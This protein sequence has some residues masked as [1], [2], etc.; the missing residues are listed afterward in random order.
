MQA[1]QKNDEIDQ[2][3]RQWRC[4]FH[5]HPETAYEEI[6]TADKIAG[7][8]TSWGI[9][10][11]RG[12]AKTGVVGTLKGNR[13]GNMIGLRADMDALDITE[14]NDFLY[15]SKNV[16]KMHACGHDGHMAML[17]GA[18]YYLSQ[19]RDFAGTVVFIFQPA[20]ENVAGGKLM[21]DEG[22]FELFPVKEVYGLHNWPDLEE[23]VIG[24]HDKEV[25]ASYDVFDIIIKGKG[26]HGAQPQKGIDPVLIA[27]HIVVALQSIV[28]RNIPPSE[29]AVL[30]VTKIHGGEMNNIIPNEVAIGGGCR[31]FSSEVRYLLK[32]NIC[33][34]ATDVANSFG[35]TV[36]IDYQLR[37]PPTVNH[38]AQAQKIAKVAEKLF[39]T[40]KV[41]RNPKPDT[42]AED[43]GIMLEHKPGAYIW[44]GKGKKSET[45]F[46]HSSSYDFN[47]EILAL[48]ASLWVEMVR[49]N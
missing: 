38:K 32:D 40:D 46:L 9:E 23:G 11:H 39:G 12:L 34:I 30:S 43:F 36:E 20:E 19:H 49:T 21:C 15:Q 8:L 26:C 24:I 35:A 31:A 4:E 14:E 10:V 25:M 47:N 17:L 6:N 22:L 7:L 1:I 45:D 42:S 16:G 3:M 5:Q 48:G 27:S 28:S 33:K 2:L 13:D 41:I 29:Q 44:L 37:Y 18:A